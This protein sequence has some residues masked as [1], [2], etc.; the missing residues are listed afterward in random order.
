MLDAFADILLLIAA[1]IAGGLCLMLSFRLKS[2][3]KLDRGVGGA[4]AVLSAQVEDLTRTLSKAEESAHASADLLRELT[5]RAEKTSRQLEMML[6]ATQDLPAPPE[7]TS[8][9]TFV[10]HERKVAE[11]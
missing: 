3:S 2:F 8:G 4:I 11:L 1:L 7:S 6:A 9:S 10:R 5:E